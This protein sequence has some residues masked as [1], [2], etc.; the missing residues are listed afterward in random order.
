MKVTPTAIPDVLI[1]EPK[2]FDDSRGFFYESFNQKQFEEACGVKVD[3]V[4]DNHSRSNKNVLRGMHF[5][6]RQPQGKLI[7]VVQGA[8]FD[9]AID[10]RASSPTFGQ[11]VGLELSACNKRML[12]IPPGFAHGFLAVSDSADVLYKT[13]D[14]WALD[15]ERSIAWN[16][17]T[18][19]VNWP[20]EGLP[21]LSAKDGLASSFATSE[22][23]P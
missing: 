1:I 6:I 16:D 20:I 14:Y 19:G 17:P 22:H 7:R 5:Q 8:I 9:V 23:F 4:Q 15:L 3:F 11:H 21:S 10:L 18:I 13:T 12:W 2:V